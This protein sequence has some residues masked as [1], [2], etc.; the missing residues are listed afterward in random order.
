MNS[1]AE[2][3]KSAR[4]IANSI[5]ELVELEDGPVTLAQ[6]NRD[7]TGF[8]KKDDPSWSYHLDSVVGRWLIWN[9][10][11]EPGLV[12]LRTVLRDRRVALQW[13]DVRLYLI[14]NFVLKNDDWR[15]V[16]LLPAKAANLDSP[17]RLLRVSPEYQQYC[18]KRAAEEKLAGYR[19]LT[20]A[21]PSLMTDQFCV[22]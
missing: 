12:A 2:V 11:T 10:M 7:I 5:V 9:G 6:I 14:E 19:A 3:G 4:K 13:V 17:D 15:P 16:L 18:L 1:K 20:P 22:S 21:L 8:A